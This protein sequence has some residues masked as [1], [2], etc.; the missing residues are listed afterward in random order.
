MMSMYFI[1]NKFKILLKSLQYPW[2]LFCFSD[3][4]SIPIS[5]SPTVS[6]GSLPFPGK[7]AVLYHDC[8][9]MGDDFF[10]ELAKTEFHCIECPSCK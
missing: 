5:I 9:I 6:I 7:T 1:F 10:L 3:I 8:E 2:L 4:A